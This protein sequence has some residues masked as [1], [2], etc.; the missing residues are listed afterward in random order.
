L[1]TKYKLLTKIIASRLEK[2][3]PWLVDTDQNGF[4]QNR[5]SI[6]N[7]RRFLNIVHCIKSLND[8]ILAVSLDA[9]KASD[10]VEWH[11]AVLHKIHFGPNML[12]MI[13]LVS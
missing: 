2:I 5:S 11:F 4:I 3:V 9:E 6:D 12:S 13:Q 7:V 8:P 10:R 1:S